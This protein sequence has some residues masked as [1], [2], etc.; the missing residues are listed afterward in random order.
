M[1]Q[2]KKTRRDYQKAC[3]PGGRKFGMEIRT[4]AQCGVVDQHR[5]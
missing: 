4:Y 2:E 1:N 5:S 3:K